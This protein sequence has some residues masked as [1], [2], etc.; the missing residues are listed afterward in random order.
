MKNK[1]G[2][3]KERGSALLMT[4]GVLALALILAMSFAFTSRAS[5][6]ISK[7]NADM[8]R[9]R[10]LAQSGLN[11]LIAAMYNDNVNTPGYY[12]A[13]KGGNLDFTGSITKSDAVI[14]YLNM[15]GDSSD[16]SE[17]ENS[18]HAILARHDNYAK[19]LYTGCSGFAPTGFQ[20]YFDDEGKVMGRIGFVVIEESGK[21]DLN[22][23]LN[24]RTEANNMPFVWA[25][26][27]RIYHGTGTF[28]AATDF[29]YNILWGYQPGTQVD[30]TNTQ[31]V[32]LHMQELRVAASYLSALPAT[33]V[34]NRKAQW[35]SY[36]HL[37]N[38]I[39]YT[40]NNTTFDDDILHYTFFSGEEPEAYW[41]QSAETA[42]PGTGERQR[43]DITGYEWRDDALGSYYTTAGGTHPNPATSGWQHPSES[44]TANASAY[45]RSLAAALRSGSQPF[46]NTSVDPPEPADVNRISGATIPADFSGIPWLNTLQPDSVRPQVAANL[47]DYCDSDS[48]A[49][50]PNTVTWTSTTEPEY[51][52]NEKVPYFNEVALAV[53][54]EKAVTL[55]PDYTFRLRI[56]P[57][58]EL[59][60]I[61]GP[62]GPTGDLH[63][64]DFQVRIIGTYQLIDNMGTIIHDDPLNQIF[65]FSNKPDVK[66]YS[67]DMTMVNPTDPSTIV[68][69]E[70]R[71]D[72]IDGA[73]FNLHITQ[74]IMISG[75]VN[76]EDQIKDY[77]FWAGD[78]T[79]SIMATTTPHQ[80]QYASLEVADP[81]FNHRSDSW[82]WYG[83]GTVFSPNIAH[84][85]IFTN[86]SN[87]NPQNDGTNTTKDIET[88]TGLALNST[89]STAFIR[90]APME[91]LWELGAIHRGAPWQTLNLR[92]FGTTGNYAD[93]DAMIL[94]Q[95]KIGPVKFSRG[96]YNANAINPEVCNELLSGIHLM[97]PYDDVTTWNPTPPTLPGTITWKPVSEFR[98]QI[99][100]TLAAWGGT[101]DQRIEAWIGRTANLLSTRNDCYTIFV[102]AQAMQELPGIDATN[103]S[104]VR[105]SVIN[106]TA[107][108]VSGTDRYCSILATQILR[109]HLVR[110]A[111][112]NT[113]QIVQQR[114]LE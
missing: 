30:E 11:R 58:V 10:L 104:A 102:V 34:A 110:D 16:A 100:N 14:K 101:T 8:I 13:R 112:R 66:S 78:V 72:D 106:P 18:L 28:N 47:V 73:T 25:D 43:F 22:Q 56:I 50:I 4:L 95:V 70:T 111:W 96:K 19:Q 60:H 26:N 107:Y 89:F 53:V 32:G 76:N 59:V 46:W 64:G 24:L 55:T 93:G 31:R 79:T 113:Y 7:V 87:F 29:Y 12:L 17:T 52:G 105:D 99:A 92:S 74:V 108:N 114:Y 3:N 97:S 86:N 37:L 80:T 51:C 68:Y 91:S 98:G 20:T 42:V 81:R 5:R 6:T 57:R 61:F 84:H 69:E 65:S 40:A 27:P 49:T 33:S 1:Q 36:D 85:T 83:G 103:F 82:A 54:A 71:S 67:Y 9:A 63:S 75:T 62:P 94:D 21:I 38:S 88:F 2:H 48:W 35:M 109:A 15:G 77:G 90:N 41:D 39:S 45:A 23:V 44:G